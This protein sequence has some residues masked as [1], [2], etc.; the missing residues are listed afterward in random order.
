ML[1]LA[2]KETQ[3]RHKTEDRLIALGGRGQIFALIVSTL[4]IGAIVLS[5][6]FSQPVASIAPAIIAISGLISIFTS[7]K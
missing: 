2:E 5:I 4:S 3:H 7:R 1:A 6:F